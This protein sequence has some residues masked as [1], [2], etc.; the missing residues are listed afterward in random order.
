MAQV[1]LP[2]RDIHWGQE[3]SATPR[4]FCSGA[5]TRHRKIKEG[6][7]AYTN[8]SPGKQSVSTMDEVALKYR[9]T[10]FPPSD[11]GTRRSQGSSPSLLP[12][13]Q[14]QGKSSPLPCGTP[15]VPPPPLWPGDSFFNRQPAFSCTINASQQNPLHAFPK[16]VIS[17]Q[18]KQASSLAPPPF[19]LSPLFLL[20]LLQPSSHQSESL[21]PLGKL[22]RFII[23]PRLS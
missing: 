4:S 6:T 15:G 2:Q 1:Q 5:R 13:T 18:N 23:R 8:T 7:S 11:C 22:G 9:R 19:H 17:I 20:F 3:L 14:L 12:T 10:P 21:P 16:S